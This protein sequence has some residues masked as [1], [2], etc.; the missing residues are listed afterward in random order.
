MRYLLILILAAGMTVYGGS[1][2]LD[3]ALSVRT[4]TTAYSVSDTRA[5]LRQCDG[6]TA[7]R[8]IYTDRVP[9]AWVVTCTQ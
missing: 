1:R 2:L 3:I 6:V 8:T 4:T 5:L 7:I 9:T